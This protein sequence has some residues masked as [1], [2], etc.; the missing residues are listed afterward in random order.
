MQVYKS[1]SEGCTFFDVVMQC[2]LSLNMMPKL[3][4]DNGIKD[5]NLTTTAGEVF[6]Y[7]TDFVSDE[8]LNN[9]VVK[10]D[11]KFCTGRPIFYDSENRFSFLIT[12]NNEYITTGV[13]QKI[14]I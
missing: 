14:K 4:L 13:E 10:N 2:Y 1:F 12:E 3:I 9:E 5:L 7:D 6:L 11:Y 8:F